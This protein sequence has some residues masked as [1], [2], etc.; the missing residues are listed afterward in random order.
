MPKI[1]NKCPHTLKLYSPEGR[2]IINI[3]PEEPPIRVAV[4]RRL[5]GQTSE[6]VPM[7]ETTYTGLEHLPPPQ[8]DVIYVVSGLV[9]SACPSRRDLW[10]PGELLRNSEGEIIGA[11]GISRPK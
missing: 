7:Y 3:P 11:I 10:Q 1:V 6:G 9:V 8:E 2:H 4:E 5:I